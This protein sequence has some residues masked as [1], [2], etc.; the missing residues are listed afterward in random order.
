MLFVGVSAEVLYLYGET[1]MQNALDYSV[2][3]NAS[4]NEHTLHWQNSYSDKQV[5]I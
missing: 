1:I 4:S 2:I 5:L 3:L